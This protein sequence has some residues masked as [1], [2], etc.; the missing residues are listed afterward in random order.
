M[1]TILIIGIFISRYISGRS[2]DQLRD[3]VY[4]GGTGH[5]HGCR[6]ING[7]S[8]FRFPDKGPVVAVKFIRCEYLTYTFRSSVSVVTTARIPVGSPA[9]I[10]AFKVVEKRSSE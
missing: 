8:S 6:T 9:L 10:V 5:F 3:A 4:D 2:I 7:N 1:N